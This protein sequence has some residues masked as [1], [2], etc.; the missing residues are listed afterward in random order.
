[1]SQDR[2]LSSSQAQFTED[3]VSDLEKNGTGL[4]VKERAVYIPPK[5]YCKRCIKGIHNIAKND[6]RC[7]GAKGT[8]DCQCPCQTHYVGRDGKLRPYDKPDD[9]LKKPDAQKPTAES[10]AFIE[11]INQQWHEDHG[12]EPKSI[13]Q[14]DKEWCEK[15]GIPYTEGGHAI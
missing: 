2:F 12:T 4:V 15:N 1:M 8:S 13:E 9:S 10:D 5:I 14:K 6:K 3:D 11:K 7:L